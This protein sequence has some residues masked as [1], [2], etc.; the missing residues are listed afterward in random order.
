[1]VE[2]SAS[3]FWRRHRHSPREQDCEWLDRSNL[4]RFDLIDLRL[5]AKPAQWNREGPET[6]P[7]EAMAFRR[8]C[9]LLGV[10]CGYLRLR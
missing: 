9:V 10:C 1:M 4:R 7:Q 2:C 5:Q 6:T 8:S 3:L